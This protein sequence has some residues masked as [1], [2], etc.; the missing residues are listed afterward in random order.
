[1][2]AP[3]EVSRNITDE[4]LEFHVTFDTAIVEVVKY[5]NMYI[6]GKQLSVQCNRKRDSK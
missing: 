6:H 5:T 3:T 4:M 2:P 1:L